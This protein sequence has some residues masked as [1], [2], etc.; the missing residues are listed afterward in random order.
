L[1]PFEEVCFE[2][3]HFRLILGLFLGGSCPEAPKRGLKGGKK[4]SKR[5]GSGP[6]EEGCFEGVSFWAHFRPVFRRVL[7]R[8]SK[9]GSK[10]GSKRGQKGLFWVILGRSILRG[11]ILASF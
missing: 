7:A 9:K 5:P 8:G 3:F 4:G 1:D 6:F 2:G 11:F 10:R